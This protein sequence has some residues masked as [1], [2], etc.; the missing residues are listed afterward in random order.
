V[1]R[2]AQQHTEAA[3]RQV[4]RADVCPM[5]ATIKPGNGSGASRS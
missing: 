1:I 2:T 5:G 3:D 4:E